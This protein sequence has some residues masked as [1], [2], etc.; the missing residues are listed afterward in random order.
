MIKNIL[1]VE[2]NEAGSRLMQEA[3]KE[4]FFDGELDIVEDGT[5]AMQFLRH[6]QRFEN[7]PKPDLVLLDLNLPGK[8]GIEVLNEIKTDEALRD[9]PVAVLT[10]SNSSKDIKACSGFQR[11]R[12]FLKP[13]RFDEIVNLVKSLE[14][15]F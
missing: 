11:C 2:D 6:E 4:V 12:Y 15:F 10:G 1:L 5:E 9:I 13:A 8:S 14:S 7:K 3:F